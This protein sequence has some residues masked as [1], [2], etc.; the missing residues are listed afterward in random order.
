MTTI[1]II[2]RTARTD[3][4]IIITV[5]VF[6]LFSSDSSLSISDVN[7]LFCVDGEVDEIVG[8]GVVDI[9]GDGIVV[10]VGVEVVID[11]SEEVESV[12]EIVEVDDGVVD[13]DEGVVDVDDG[14]VDVDDGVVDV[15]EG[16]GEG[17]DPDERSRIIGSPRKS[18]SG[19]I[20]ET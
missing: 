4:T 1:T 16:V 7:P 9:V 15:D 6:V 10:Y 17:S 2:I 12:D 14:V 13:V 3:E 11:E 5:V 8:N 18:S 20:S 19:N